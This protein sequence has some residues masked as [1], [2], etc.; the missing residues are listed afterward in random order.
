V[1]QQQ[2][3]TANGVCPQCSGAGGSIAP[4]AFDGTTLFVAGAA[5][6]VKGQSCAGSLNAL[7]PATGAFE[8][9]D[10]LEGSVLSAVVEVP[11]IVATGYGTHLLVAN[12]ST[13]QSLFDYNSG[14]ALFFGAP[15]VSNGMVFA[16]NYSGNLLAFDQ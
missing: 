1:W 2:I 15:A 16:V 5:T 14:G 3:A 6:T 11:G 7:N 13:G 8:W 10:C 12:A 9:Q 4:A